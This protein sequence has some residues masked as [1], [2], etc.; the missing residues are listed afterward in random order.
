MTNITTKIAKISSK[1]Q[2]T[3]PK[4]F[5]D[6]MGLDHNQDII[7]R[8]VDGK[9]EISNKQK[10][11]QEKLKNLLPIDLGDSQTVY[12]SQNHNEIYDQ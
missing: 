4:V 9:I 2:I 5:L 8:L 6:Q 12:L 3:L 7:I 11:Q 1:G 10:I